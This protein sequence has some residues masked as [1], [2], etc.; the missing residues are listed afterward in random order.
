MKWQ[1]G[2]FTVTD[3]RED[4]DIEV[5]HGFLCRESYWAEHIPR[6][7][8]EKAI[9]HSLCFGLYHAGKQI[10]FARAV[11]DHATFAYLADVFVLSDYRGRGLGKW[12]V[13]C[14]LIHPELQGLRRWMLATLDAHRLY[15]QNGFVPLRHPEWFLEIHYPDIYCRKE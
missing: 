6:A 7:T 1:Q 10:G 2:D 12:L 11:S 15:E 14:I 3:N 9:T 5:I 4:L 13:S 8:V